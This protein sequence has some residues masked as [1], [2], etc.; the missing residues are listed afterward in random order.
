MNKSFRSRRRDRKREMVMFALLVI[1]LVAGNL[2]IPEPD[3]VLSSGTARVIDGDSIVVDGREIRL[4][5]IDA[6]E[7]AQICHRD[8]NPWRCGE[9]AQR[10]LRFFVRGGDVE[11]EGSE[12]DQHGRLLGVCRIAG[13]DVNGWMVKEGWAISF[14][15]YSDAEA[16]ARDG[17]RGL[18]SARFERPQDWRDAHPRQ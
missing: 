10:Q 16:E 9:E 8:G 15:G 1:A 2:L 14:G 4:K 12:Y 17:L 7:L 3:P 5:G 18:W 13:R 6:P 11:C